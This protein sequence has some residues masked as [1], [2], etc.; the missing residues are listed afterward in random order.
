MQVFLINLARS[1]DRLAF[2]RAQLGGRFERLEAV[3][4]LA[5]PERLAEQFSSTAHLRPGEIGCYASHLLAAEWIVERGLPYALIMEDDVEVSAEF[6][7]AA[8]WAVATCPAGWDHISLCG[9]RLGKGLNEK[10]AGHASRSLTRFL[11][12]PKGTGAYILS[13]SGATKLLKSRRRC[14]PVDVDF[15]YGYGMNFATYGVVPPPSRQ[16]PDFSTTIVGRK[17]RSHWRIAPHEYLLG[18][19]G[20]FLRF[21]IRRSV[22]A[23]VGQ[24]ASS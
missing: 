8:D 24:L 14:R 9:A 10:V 20:Q 21:G 17:R 12:A 5:I 1:P 6:F 15:H 4:G 18:R 16:V 11:R 3:A 22:R 13:R 19:A 7:D 2:M 23:M